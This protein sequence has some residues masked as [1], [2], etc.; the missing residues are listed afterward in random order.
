MRTNTLYRSAAML[1]L[2]TSCSAWAAP[3]EVNTTLLRGSGQPWGGVAVDAGSGKVYESNHFSS[4]TALKTYANV[5]DFEA[6]INAVTIQTDARDGTYMAA[7]NGS[8]FARAY[9][10]AAARWGQFDGSTGA[11]QAQHEISGLGGDNWNDSFDWGG[12]SAVNAMSDGAHLYAVGGAAGGVSQLSPWRINRYDAGMNLL[13]SFEM[14]LDGQDPGF[15]FAMGGYLFF[16][17][18]Y[19]SGRISRRVNTVTGAV[20]AV[21]YELQ[22]LDSS[23]YVSSIS[24]DAYNDS[25]YI[26][27]GFSFYKVSDAFAAFGNPGL[28][29]EL[30][31]PA[32]LALCALALLA[33]GGVSARHHGRSRRSALPP[34]PNP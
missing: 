13:N 2:M 23:I 34:C 5:A 7:M 33:A 20:E 19:N 28:N 24:Y 29:G 14:D 22:G 21:D 17:D 11:Q 31:E 3:I 27:S 4:Q 18:H 25:L 10:S 30:P 15:A 6:G 26:H 1:L 8:L 9:G 16:G 12:F 32:N